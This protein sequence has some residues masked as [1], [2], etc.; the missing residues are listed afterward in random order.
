[1]QRNALS[2]FSGYH[3]AV[4]FL[5]FGTVFGFSMFSMHPVC[6]LFSFLAAAGYYISLRDAKALRFLLRGVLPLWLFT[7]IINPVFSHEGQTVLCYLPTGNPLTLE[8]ILYGIAAGFLLASFLLWFAC[9]S[10]V[11][12]SDK[13][14]YLFGRIIPSLSLLLS[15]TLRFVPRFSTQLEHVREVQSMLGRDAS[16][17]GLL[18][19]IRNAVACFSI[20]VTWSLESAIET[21][22]SMKSRGYGTGRRTA[23]SVYRWTDRDT[24]AAVFLL[25]CAL[26]LLAGSLYGNLSWRYFHSV[27]GALTDP[28]TLALQAVWL[29]LCLMPI[30]IDRKEERA[31]KRLSSGI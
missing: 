2:G 3:P 28:P 27:R 29:L 26:F 10:E 30:I 24:A 7:I 31:W 12:T 11:V 18:K 1:M 25:L 16:Q 20:V 6:L 15:M 8:S 14:I 17:S 21:A 23:Y 5:F 4:N 9:F 19:R 22:D 13:L